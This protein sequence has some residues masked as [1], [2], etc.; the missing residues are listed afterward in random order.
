MKKKYPDTLAILAYYEAKPNATPLE[1]A[2]ELKLPLSKVYSVRNNYL[3]GATKKKRPVKRIIAEQVP[4]NKVDD[5]L[6]DRAKD[7]GTFIEGA[8]IMQMLK[9]I[10]H[11]YIEQRGTPLAFDQREAIDMIVHKLGRIINGNPDKAD[12]WRDVAGYA[13]LV[14][15]RLEGQAR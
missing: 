1:V 7:Y 9:R 4:V 2:N 13:T 10:V 15:D 5:I 11:N 12:S 8:E 14:A 6:N 3:R